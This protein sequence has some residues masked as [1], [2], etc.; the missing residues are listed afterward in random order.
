MG[1]TL[2]LVLVPAILA[3]VGAWMIFSS[4]RTRRDAERAATW[5]T[6][7]GT[8]TSAE[9]QIHRS[10]NSRT[11]TTTTTYEPRVEYTYTV[12]GTPYSGKRVCFG[13]RSFA[14][15]K[16]Q[17]I[18]DRYPA[19]Q[20]VPVYYNTENPADS[21]LDLAAPNT[22]TTLVFGIIFGAI[23]LVSA[24]ILLITSLT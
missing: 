14:H 18:L 12:M 7:P 2:M 16:A 22:T 6:A 24:V 1:Q 17:A 21:V 11:H 23:G 10:H 20:A 13:L 15:D 9:M 5:P 8:V 19:G 3:L 4:I